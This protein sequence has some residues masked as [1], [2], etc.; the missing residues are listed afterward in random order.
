[1]GSPPPVHNQTLGTLSEF[2]TEFMDM[3]GPAGSEGLL[4]LR[5]PVPALRNTTPL[6]LILAG[7]ID[8]VTTVLGRANRGEMA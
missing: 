4:W 3:F 8:Q 6:D 5:T 2:V 7:K 1:M